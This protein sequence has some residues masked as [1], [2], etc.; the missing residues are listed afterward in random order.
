MNILFLV[1]QSRALFIALTWLLLYYYTFQQLRKDSLQ[2]KVEKLQILKYHFFRKGDEKWFIGAQSQSN[3]SIFCWLIF[4]FSSEEI[5]WNDP[6]DVLMI[7]VTAVSVVWI[8]T[9]NQLMTL[10]SPAAVLYWSG[11]QDRPPVSE[12][13]QEQWA[14][15]SQVQ[16]DDHQEADHAEHW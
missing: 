6:V 4:I 5:R 14:D 10:N 12:T 9:F 15:G 3:S 1:A 13:E 8:R 16:A 7:S 2:T 11:C